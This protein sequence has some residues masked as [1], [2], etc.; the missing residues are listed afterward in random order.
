M[1]FS[2]LL[3]PPDWIE[4]STPSL[5]MTCSTT[6]LRRQR[7]PH[8]RP[9]GARFSL[10]VS[11]VDPAIAAKPM[12][13]WPLAFSCQRPGGYKL[14]M[15]G[16]R[17]DETKDRGGTKTRR[18]RLEEALRANLAKRKAQKKARREAATTE[19]DDRQKADGD[20]D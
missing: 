13:A 12:Q 5:P 7:D 4:Q 2:L 9:S 8:S 15:T 18:E 6:E 11:R 3:V 14:G 10:C 1:I 16:N 19:D 20:G 17:Y